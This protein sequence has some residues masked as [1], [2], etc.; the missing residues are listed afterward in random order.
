MNLT[1]TERTLRSGE[2]YTSLAMDAGNRFYMTPVIYDHMSG[3]R[4]ESDHGTASI[5]FSGLD[6]GLTI[7]VSVSDL[8]ELAGK[9]A[10]RLKEWNACSDALRVH[11]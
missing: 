10:E 1:K 7:E 2:T 6:C 9:I 11:Q 5:L 8:R 4:H 3:K